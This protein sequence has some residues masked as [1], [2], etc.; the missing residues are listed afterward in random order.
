MRTRELIT[1]IEK[2][3]SEFEIERKQLEAEYTK[4]QYTLKRQARK[5]LLNINWT[6]GNINSLKKT[7][8][9]AKIPSKR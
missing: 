9:M 2:S 6:R 5:L 8:M 1:F 3:L 7:L 4:K